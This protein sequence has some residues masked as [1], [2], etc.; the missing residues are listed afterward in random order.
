MMILTDTQSPPSTLLNN[1]SMLC[2]GLVMLYNSLANKEQE[3][4]QEDSNNNRSRCP[5]TGK[6]TI[7]LNMQKSLFTTTNDRLANIFTKFMGSFFHGIYRLSQCIMTTHFTS[8]CPVNIK[9]RKH[10]KCFKI[11]SST[12]QESSPVVLITMPVNINQF[13]KIRN[14]NPWNIIHSNKS[15]TEL[16]GKVAVSPVV[17]PKEHIK[18][19]YTLVKEVLGEELDVS[20]YF[21][22]DLMM[23]S[24]NM[25]EVF[26]TSLEQEHS[27]K[28]IFSGYGHICSCYQ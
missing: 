5:F 21:N 12:D 18:A 8:R 2:P 9:K 23:E 27:L 22:N 15:V 7:E 16:L 17:L 3:T 20:L 13:R 24:P 28:Q 10:P 11:V 6:H 14:S 25:Y 1:V 26:E 19:Q 4:K